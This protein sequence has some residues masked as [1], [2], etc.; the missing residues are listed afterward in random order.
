MK[1]LAVRTDKPESEIYWVDDDMVKKYTWEAHR[2]L[3]LTVNSKIKEYLDS[4]G[5]NVSNCDGIIIFSGEGSFTGLRIGFSVA[6]ALAYSHGIKIVTSTGE[7]WIAS[8][9]AIIESQT[10]KPNT[11]ASPI[12]SSPV[13]ITAQKR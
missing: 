1:Y 2:Q 7:G 6:N 8:G 12:Y 4:L 3:S 9:I 10:K 5:E 13:H 11:Y